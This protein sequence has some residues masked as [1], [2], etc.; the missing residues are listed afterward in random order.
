ML[1]LELA[2]SHLRGQCFNH[3][4]TFQATDSAISEAPVCPDPLSAAQSGRPAFNM[5]SVT[6]LLGLGK[7]VSTGEALDSIP[8][9]KA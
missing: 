9:A 1:G 2:T 5:D 8:P 6:F 4:T 7:F 3:W